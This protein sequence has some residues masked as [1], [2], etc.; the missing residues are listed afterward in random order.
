MNRILTSLLLTAL[1]TGLGACEGGSS[2]DPAQP[3]ELVLERHA[4]VAGETTL[5]PVGVAVDPM[6]GSRFVLDRSNRLYDVSEEGALALRIDL[7]E[8]WGD[9]PLQDVCAVSENEV[10]TVAP[11]FGLKV[12]LTTQEAQ[13]HFCLEPE[14]KQLIG[15]IAQ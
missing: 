7:A 14:M 2:L 11:G 15:Q 13:S 10:F 4:L 6:T 1:V 8:T 9:E 12:N 3:Q 5:D